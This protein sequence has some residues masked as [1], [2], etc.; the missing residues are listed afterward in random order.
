[1]WLITSFWGT[2]S[3]FYWYTQETA[4]Y[5]DGNQ[6]TFTFHHRHIIPGLCLSDYILALSKTKQSASCID[7][8][9]S[10]KV[11]SGF[12]IE[13]MPKI[14]PTRARLSF[15]CFMIVVHVCNSFLVHISVSSSPIKPKV[16]V[17][18]VPNFHATPNK[19][20]WTLLIPAYCS[21]VYTHSL[22]MKS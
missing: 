13:T 8:R 7:R 17:C 14:C 5:K 12:G 1:M 4:T 2:F 20:K 9:P 15:T 22:W 11:R 3:D 18:D 21:T 19:N 10:P 6:V 16:S